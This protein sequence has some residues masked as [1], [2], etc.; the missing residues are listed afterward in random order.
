MAAF[1]AIASSIAVLSLPLFTRTTLDQ[2]I[3]T[4]KIEAL[5]QFA[6]GLFG[7]ILVAASASFVELVLLSYVGNQI[8]KDFRY[9]LFAHMQ[10]LPVAFFDRSRSGVLAS[11]LSNDVDLLQQA[12]ADDLVQFV[13]NLVTI[14]GGAATAFVID[15][16]LT[17]LVIG[18]MAGLMGL[19]FTL[20]RRLRPIAR[21]TRRLRI[22]VGGDD[23]SL[24]E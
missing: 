22:G 2:A 17:C 6:L 19:L 11:Y 13:S 23:R 24:S 21:G 1:L 20:G 18:L 15:S 16:R 3:L 5:N 4:R 9:R 7:L 12:L 14:I 10:R 8:V